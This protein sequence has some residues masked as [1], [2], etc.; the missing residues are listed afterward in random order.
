MIDSRYINIIVVFTTI[1][2][3]IFTAVFMFAP[4]ALGIKR[5][6]SDP[7]YIE[8]LF[9]DTK[10]NIINIEM[11][12]SDWQ[13]FLADAMSEQ[14]AAC[15]LTINGTTYKNVGIR[16]KGNTSLSQVDNDK[17]SFKFK[18][19]KYVSDQSF[20]GLD[21]FV[22]NNIIQDTT[23]MK[24]Y[25]SYDMLD[26]IGVP[27]PA[28]AYYDVYV[29]GEEWGVYL[30]LEALEEQFVNR[31]FDPDNNDQ[32]YKV[33]T[34]SGGMPGGNGEKPELSAGGDGLA[35]AADMSGGGNMPQNFNPDWKN[36]TD[37]QTDVGGESANEKI[38][39]KNDKN[40]ASGEISEAPNMENPDGNNK[41]DFGMMPG[42]NG[43]RG[44]SGASLEYIDDEVSSYSDIF[45]YAKFDPNTSDKKRMIEAIKALNTGE[46]IEKYWNTDEIIRYFAANTAMVNLDS[47]VSQLV[48]NYYLYEE[49]GCVSVIPWDYN[50]SF[51]AF[52]SGS[53][54]SSVNFPIDT[55]VS[56][57]IS[58]EDRPLLNMIFN[59]SEYL[60]KYHEYLQDIA[61]NYFLG[62]RFET[63]VKKLKG[64]LSDNIKNQNAERAFYT[65]DEYLDAVEMLK[66]YCTLR[67]ESIIGQLDGLIPSTYEGQQADADSLIDSSSIDMSIM[68]SQ[69]KGGPDG[70]PGEEGFPKGMFFKAK[71]EKGSAG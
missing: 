27:T 71:P 19:D 37:F 54:D 30:A 52:Q 32:L 46:D 9:N 21:E 67:A 47:Y 39:R 14:Y 23:Y 51:G 68:G 65:Y 58:V 63:T 17:Y 41:K 26:Y 22:V 18:A 8:T 1:I 38:A 36:R 53:A 12:E 57:E 59:N 25:I 28:K 49:D 13:Q 16:C 64:L 70:V 4:H 55:P 34:V 31:N 56:S 29:N 20:D 43:N 5:D 6:N 60:E 10:M 42:F 15:D 3:V 44:S 33:E 62:G 40:D 66:D 61:E 7:D 50:L 48:H 69:N 45:D 24:E 35:P 2:A 11:D